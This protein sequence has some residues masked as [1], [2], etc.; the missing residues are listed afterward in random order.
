M[1][2]NTNR[3]INVNADPGFGGQTALQAAAGAGHLDV[4]KHLLDAGADVNTK[5]AGEGQLTALHAVA[6]AGHSDVARKLV[7]AGATNELRWDDW[8]FLQAAARH[9]RLV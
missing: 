1:N 7:D 8:T 5:Q 3:G 6:K 2:L 4:V 9:D